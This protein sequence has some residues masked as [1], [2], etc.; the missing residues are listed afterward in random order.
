[1]VVPP[2]SINEPTAKIPSQVFT[3]LMP[4]ITARQPLRVE[5][6]LDVSRRYVV[7]PPNGSRMPANSSTGT[8]PS[9]SMASIIFDMSVLVG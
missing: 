1:M 4:F 9:L 8:P 5:A 2:Q 7:R 6:P 3:F